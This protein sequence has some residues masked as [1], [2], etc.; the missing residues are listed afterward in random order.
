MAIH[1]KLLVCTGVGI[2]PVLSF[3]PSKSHQSCLHKVIEKL[4][5]TAVYLSFM[6]IQLLLRNWW[7]FLCLMIDCLVG[8]TDVVWWVHIFFFTVI[9][10]CFLIRC[11]ASFL[12]NSALT[13]V[14]YRGAL[15]TPDRSSSIL[16][17]ESMSLPASAQEESQSWRTRCSTDSKCSSSLSSSSSSASFH[18]AAG[19]FSRRDLEKTEIMINL[20]C[21]FGLQCRAAPTDGANAWSRG[22]RELVHG[23]YCS[24]SMWAEQEQPNGCARRLAPSYAAIPLQASTLHIKAWPKCQFM[25]NPEHWKKCQVW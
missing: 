25:F 17:S 23:E 7:M 20:T 3:R 14:G 11:S 15:S 8:H 1:H 4:G 13:S 2:G 12:Q 9:D 19:W 21:T 6:S 24:V 18:S 22:E 5:M 10:E 16:T